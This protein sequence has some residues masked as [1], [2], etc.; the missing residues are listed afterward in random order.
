MKYFWIA[1]IIGSLA[2]NIVAVWGFFTYIKYG[3]SP[4]GELKRKLTGTTHQT[5]PS[6]P[7]ADDNSNLIAAI[8]D[9]SA[10]PDRVVFFGASITQRWDFDRSLRPDFN[11]VNRGVGGQLVPQLLTRFKRD[12]LDLKPRAVIIKFCSINIRPH[13]P[14]PVLQDGLA[15]MT[16]LA[17]SHGIAPIVATIIP[18]GKPEARI[19]DFSVVDSLQAFNEW[20]RGFAAQQGYPLIDFAA[21]IEDEHG[22]LPRECSV[23]PVHLNDRGYEI[24]EDAMRPVLRDLFR[25][26]VTAQ[27]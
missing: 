21:A 16:D 15:M 11:I 7:Y 3:G 26:E 8:E 12:V 25:E 1:V 24:L 22:F 20:A 19:G 18:A 9:G 6:I 2:L 14:M 10:A 13:Q 4:L 23:D 5:S 27:R 17:A